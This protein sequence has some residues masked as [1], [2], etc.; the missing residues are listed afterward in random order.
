MRRI[1]TRD[2]QALLAD[3]VLVEYGL[4][5]GE[6]LAAV[7]TGTRVEVMSVAPV[8]SVRE[9][10]D[11]LGF[12]LRTLLRRAGD[13]AAAKLVR[14][15][16]ERIARLRQILVEPLALPPDQEMVVVPVDLLQTVPWSA[17]VDAPVSLSPSA[18]FWASALQCARPTSGKVLLAAGP[19]LSAAEGEVRRLS[20]VHE[21]SEVL[22]PPESTVRRVAEALEDAVTA[23]FACHGTIR[24][25]NPMFSGLLLSDGHLTVQELELR[26]LAPYRVILAACESSAD[27]AYTGGELLGFVSALIARGTA[28][29]L[30]SIQLVPDEATAQFM[31]HVHEHLSGEVTLAAALHSARGSLDVDDPADLV[32]WC[33]FT[34]YGAA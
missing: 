28:G 32:N 15:A 20:Q 3:R 8:A 4:L 29:V 12:M 10:L 14:L 25:D 16:Q 27:I 2:L 33:G 17:L 6:V 22:S 7:V 24:A 18:S 26:D 5:D 23:H 9:E 11:P 30:G 34:A 1:P 31:L 19:G 21:L 13:P